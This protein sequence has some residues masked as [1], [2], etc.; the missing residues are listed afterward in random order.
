MIV[1]QKERLEMR[2]NSFNNSKLHHALNSQER[3]SPNV[4][5]P[6]N[7]KIKEKI[8]SALA[9]GN[10]E[11]LRRVGWKAIREVQSNSKADYDCLMLKIYI[12]LDPEDEQDFELMEKMLNFFGT[13]FSPKDEGEICPFIVAHKE[14]SPEI[15]QWAADKMIELEASREDLYNLHN[16]IVDKNVRNWLWNYIGPAPSS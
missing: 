3:P 10:K 16:L 7:A 8:T 14:C 12:R 9:G 5:D 11:E 13:N 15:E 2:P 4:P 6:P 1:A